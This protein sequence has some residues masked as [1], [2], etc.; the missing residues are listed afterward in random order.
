MVTN[1]LSSSSSFVVVFRREIPRL[2]G[3][4]YIVWKIQME[5]HLICLGKEIWEITENGVTPFNPTF[6]DPPLTNLD[7]ELENDCRAREALF[8]ALTDQ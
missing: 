8:C 3:T 1:N 4:N 2:D 7:K 5:T 6:G